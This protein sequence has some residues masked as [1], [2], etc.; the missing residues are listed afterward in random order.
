MF[1][2]SFPGLLPTSQRKGPGN[3]VASFKLSDLLS[4][5]RSFDRDRSDT[6]LIGYIVNS[7]IYKQCPP[8]SVKIRSDI[9]SP[10][11]FV[12]IMRTVFRERSSRKTVI[13]KEQIMLKVKYPSIF[14]R[15]MPGFSFVCNAGYV[16]YK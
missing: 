2:T 16:E 11:L 6:C 7:Q 14:S 13:F 15:Q 1:A 10:T 9:C 4:F 12:P 3:E 5:N 8:F